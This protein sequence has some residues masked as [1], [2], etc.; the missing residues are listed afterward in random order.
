MSFKL[1]QVAQIVDNHLNQLVHDLTSLYEINFTICF[2]HKSL[3]SCLRVL[4]D[5]I[6]HS[7]KQKTISNLYSSFISVHA[8][9]IK[10][11]INFNENRMT[12]C[13]E[14]QIINHNIN[15]MNIDLCEHMIALS[16]ENSNC[17]IWLNDYLD[18]LLLLRES[19]S[20][21]INLLK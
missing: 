9:S 18:T 4:N 6:K 19:S 16:R 1:I 21:L 12:L 5:S 15:L 2:K 13:I 7:I 20:N 11:K 14:E 17:V 3:S 10:Y 8:E